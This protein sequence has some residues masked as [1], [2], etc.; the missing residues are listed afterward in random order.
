MKQESMA[1]VEVGCLQAQQTS[2]HD[3]GGVSRKCA[4][5]M[6]RVPARTPEGGAMIAM[7]A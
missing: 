1:E 4:P 3:R 6:R 7:G 5:G 2:L